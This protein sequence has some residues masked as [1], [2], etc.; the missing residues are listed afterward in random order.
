MCTILFLQIFFAMGDCPSFSLSFNCIMFTVPILVA[1]IR[2]TFQKKAF[3]G[4]ISSFSLLV[5]IPLEF[6]LALT[7]TVLNIYFFPLI[8][9]DMDY[10]YQFPT[11]FLSMDSNLFLPRKV[12]F[13]LS[14]PTYLFQM[15]MGTTNIFLLQCGH[16]M[17]FILQTNSLEPT[18]IS[19]HYLYLFIC[20]Y[21]FIILFKSF[22]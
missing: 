16:V 22:W 8:L 17:L 18:Y 6:L 19:F 11:F 7:S 21:V 1:L 12:L 3:L 5:F 2:L 9:N 20:I 15:I 4:I 10:T 14:I 13:A